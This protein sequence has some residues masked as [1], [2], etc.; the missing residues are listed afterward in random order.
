[1]KA[2]VLEKPL[3]RFVVKT[4]DTP[5]PEGFEVLVKVKAAGLCHT[6][7]HIWEG[8]YGPLKVEE[9]GIKFP[10]ILGHEISGEVAEIGRFVTG[11][12]QGEKVVVFPWIGCG[13]CK[14]CR[15]G[16]ENLCIYGTKP[17]GIVRQGGFADFVLVP[18]QRYLIK[19]DAD[20]SSTAP[21]A[22]AG[23]TAYN[24][25]K[26]AEL[27]PGDNVA[28]IGMGGVGHIALQ[29]VKRLYGASIIAIDVRDNALE[30]AE[31]MG[32][33]YTINAS[34]TDVVKE[35]QKITNNIGLDAVIDFVAHTDTISYA[36]N[37][38]KRGGKL[39]VV[40]IG[41]EYTN[42]TLPLIPL[43][44][45][46][47]HGSYVGSIIDLLEVLELYKRGVINVSTSLYPLEQVNEVFEMLRTGKIVGRAVFKL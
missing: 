27:S 8:H 32:A 15:M 5:K 16:E 1:L 47:I 31:K 20:L 17:L 45:V 19:V 36:F 34:K 14:A 2:A 13:L 28:L 39:V 30:L 9:R 38:L 29:M 18:H 26:K 23:I 41:G 37:S 43:R 42:L 4:V 25:V 7:I 11:F 3:E 46:K 33:E 21:L 6:D 12:E 44:N 35:V 40:G 10:L 24:A 22:C